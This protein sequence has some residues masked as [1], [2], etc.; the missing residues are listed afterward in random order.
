MQH[1]AVFQ[2]MIMCAMKV[3]IILVILSLF[4]LVIHVRSMSDDDVHLY[5]DLDSRGFWFYQIMWSSEIIFFLDLRPLVGK[6][7]IQFDPQGQHLSHIKWCFILL[8]NIYLYFYYEDL[9]I[10]FGIPVS[11]DGRWVMEGTRSFFL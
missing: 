1:S 5:F 7:V 9:I 8:S 6:G 4:K 11:C 10:L 2:W 3:K